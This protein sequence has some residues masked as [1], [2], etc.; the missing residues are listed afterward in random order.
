V[1]NLLSGSRLQQRRLLNLLRWL[2][3]ELQIPLVA[4]GTHDALHAIQ[5]DDQ[6]ANRFTP[7]GLPPWRDG[8]TYRKLLS[9]LEAV[10]PLKRPSHLARPDLAARI[11]AS[12]EGIL[13]EIISVVTMAAV[14]AIQ[15]GEECISTTLLD[16]CGFVAPSKRRRVAS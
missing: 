7:V 8:D 3:N 15:N 16:R 10:L 1:H 11:L 2:G 14:A 6:L 5:S 4:V 9:T 13:G 12:S